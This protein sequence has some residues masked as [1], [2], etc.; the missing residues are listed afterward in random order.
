MTPHC[1]SDSGD[2]GRERMLRE[3]TVGANGRRHAALY[4]EVVSW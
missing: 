1:G 4:R 3:F 2:A